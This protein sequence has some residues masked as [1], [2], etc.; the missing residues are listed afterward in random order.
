M[1]LV[2]GS[3]LRRHTRDGDPTLTFHPCKECTGGSQLASP[4]AG[5]FNPT[6]ENEL[7]QSIKVLGPAELKNQLRRGWPVGAGSPYEAPRMVCFAMPS[8]AKIIA[9]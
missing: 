1:R 9:E 3:I 5:R 4:F 7:R 2:P 6:S 8:S